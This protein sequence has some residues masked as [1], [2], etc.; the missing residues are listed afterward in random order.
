MMT[1][2]K[3]SPKIVIAR[4]NASTE[5][6]KSFDADELVVLKKL[7]LSDDVVAAMVEVTSKVEERRRADEERQAMRAEIA[8][9]KAMIAEKKAEGAGGKGEM[10]Q[11]KDGPMDVLASCAKRLGALKLCDQIPFPGSSICSSTAESAFPCPT[12]K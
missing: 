3:I 2:A 9:L 8:A 4:V 11:T 10:V 12:N 6:Y 7:G 1:D 5:P